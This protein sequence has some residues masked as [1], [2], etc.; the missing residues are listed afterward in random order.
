MA[1]VAH[2]A[3]WPCPFEAS[4]G[5]LRSGERHG[6]PLSLT[7]VRRPVPHECEGATRL[8]A[9]PRPVCLRPMLV[10]APGWS[11]YWRGGRSHWRATA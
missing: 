9:G 1:A 4:P 5:Q 6:T 7:E 2:R 10:D 8:G 11:H 3:L